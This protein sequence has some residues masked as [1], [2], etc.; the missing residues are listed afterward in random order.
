ME[1][2]NNEKFGKFLTELRKERNITQ[3]ELAEKIGVSDK[4]V[5]KWERG[6]SFPDITLL[7]PISSV[8]EISLTELYQGERI[9][10]DAKLEIE[11]VDTILNNSLQIVAEDTLKQQ[12]RQHKRNLLFLV[13]ILVAIFEFYYLYM[14]QFIPTDLV[15]D[16]RTIVLLSFIF[17]SYFT[18]FVKAKLPVY[19]DQYKLNFYARGGIKMH[20][21]GLVLNNNN[22]QYI[23]S[24]ICIGC[25]FLL[26]VSPI[27][28]YLYSAYQLFSFS[29]LKSLLYTLTFGSILLPVYGAAY[30]YK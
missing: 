30:R 15:N 7:G 21:T 14:H 27:L 23:I 25:A 6:L 11:K 13:S 28:V 12:N 18:F 3:K 29:V 2:I 17:L 9:E 19:Y 10:K 22:W 8:L 24:A 5:S 26:I 1:T 16:L 20:L 4:A